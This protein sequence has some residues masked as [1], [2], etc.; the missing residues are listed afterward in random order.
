MNVFHKVTSWSINN[1]EVL[2]RALIC[3]L[4]SL[5]LL[6]IDQNENYDTRFKARGVQKSS[7]QIVLITINPSDGV[8][9]VKRCE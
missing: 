2:F 4:I 1:K 7:E 6:V 8:L 3:W 5:F 9:K